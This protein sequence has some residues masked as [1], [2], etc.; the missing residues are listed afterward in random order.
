MIPFTLGLIGGLLDRQGFYFV[1]AACVILTVHYRL[2]GQL[3]DVLCASISAAIALQLYNLVFAPLTIRSLN[4]YWPEFSYQMIPLAE[5]GRLPNHMLRASALLLENTALLLGGFQ[6]VALTVVALVCALAWRRMAWP[7]DLRHP[8]RLWEHLRHNAPSR[9]LA[10]CV[11]AMGLH[12]V[13]FGLMIARH[14]YV[15]R[16]MDHRYWYYTIPFLASALFGILLGLEGGMTHL[17]RHYR[18][19]LP[20]VLAIVALSNGLSLA[21]Y[22]QI[23]TR[24]EWFGPVHTQCTALKASLRRGVAEPGLD[25]EYRAFFDHLQRPSR[26]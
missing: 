14:G 25:P 3:R 18:R 10:Y 22:R 11:L 4:G 15:Y 17:P 7:A 13:M 1:V 23:M 6:V 20:L 9:V 24:G 19:L 2:T 21:H 26:R 5:I 16:W 8:A 12:I